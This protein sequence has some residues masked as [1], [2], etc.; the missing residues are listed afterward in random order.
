MQGRVAPIAAAACISWHKECRR[1][2]ETPSSCRRS[3]S[4]IRG[5]TVF[6]LPASRAAKSEKVCKSLNRQDIRVLTR[7]NPLGYPDDMPTTP[8]KHD[9]ILI[10]ISVEDKKEIRSSIQN[11]ELSDIARALLLM[12]VRDP[13]LQVKVNI[14]RNPEWQQP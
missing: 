14:M 4:Y 8:K 5:E 9:R 10:K 11:G 7:C 2:K 3:W 12:Y 1:H 6:I 13:V